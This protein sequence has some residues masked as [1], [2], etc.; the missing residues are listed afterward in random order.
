LPKTGLSPEEATARMLDRLV[1]RLREA[2]G[3][4]LL[5][6][7]VY[8]TPA[9]NRAA[10]GAAETNVLVVLA[11]AVL[12]ALL[13]IAPILTSAQRQSQVA[14]FVATPAEL[15]S[16]AELFPARLLELRLTHRVLYGDVHLERLQIA[17][18]SLRFAAL[19]ELRGVELRLRHRILDRGATPDQ[20]W[21]GIVQGLPR[22]LAIV[23]MVAHAGG[24]PPACPRP[25][26]L[27]TAAEA[28]HIQPDALE[29]MALLRGLA[30]RPDDATVREHLAEYL[31]LLTELIEHLG[32][33][34]AADAPADAPRH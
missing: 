6:V 24:A 4:N 26:L 18:P 25:E 5:G 10:S 13:P 1:E 20:L 28:L 16:D 15:R 23:E 14:S 3:E 17:P 33:L 19:Q 2:A 32:H 21:A 34:V 30:R 7:A 27:R 12:T 9:K 29:K 8:G 31:A 22:L 11:D